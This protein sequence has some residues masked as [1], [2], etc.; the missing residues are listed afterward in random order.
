MNGP[1]QP[2]DVGALIESCNRGDRNAW[3]R[4]YSRY[5]PVVRYAVTK[6]FA[7]RPEEIEDSTQEVFLHL[8][9]A[10]KSYD[11]S[12]PL[13]TY[14]L[15]IA[16]R[17]V[18]SRFRS[19]SALKRGGAHP[20]RFGIDESGSEKEAGYVCLAAQD[21]TQEEVLIK[22]EETHRLRRALK[23][24]TDKCR[25]LLLLRY[26]GGFSYTEIA[27]KLDVKEGTLRVRVQRCLSSLATAYA[28]LAAPGGEP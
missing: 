4:F 16:R 8:F 25:D 14:I 20:R 10:L 2:N 17:V 3:E 27:L 18:I 28:E 19:V 12:R 22:A 15:E 7:S 24:L 26:D 21:Q 13:E 23:K 5:L 9:R 11:P 6:L 1:K